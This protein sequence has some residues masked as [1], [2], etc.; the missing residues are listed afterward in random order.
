MMHVNQ[1]TSDGVIFEGGLW[2]DFLKFVIILYQLSQSTLQYM[3][4]VF[5]VCEVLHTLGIYEFHFPSP[6]NCKAFDQLDHTRFL[7]LQ[8]VSFVFLEHNFRFFNERDQRSEMGNKNLF[9]ELCDFFRQVSVHEFRFFAFFA[10]SFGENGEQY[11]VIVYDEN[12]LFL[13]VGK[14]FRNSVEKTVYFAEQVG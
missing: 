4:A 14:L 13:P 2:E 10:R 5:E 8:F 1:F 11:V 3:S 7:L 12:Q 6:L 9:D